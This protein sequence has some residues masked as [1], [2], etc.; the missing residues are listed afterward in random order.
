MDSSKVEPGGPALV[1]GGAM[2]DWLDPRWRLLRMIVVNSLMK[3]MERLRV[4]KRACAL[5]VYLCLII[6][7][8]SFFAPSDARKSSHL[9]RGVRG[10]SRS[11][12]HKTSKKVVKAL[13]RLDI[14][15]D[16]QLLL[17]DDSTNSQPYAVSSPFNLPPFNSLAPISLP[18]SSSTPP[19]C[20]YPPSNPQLPN[21]PS[22]S[23]PSPPIGGG[24]VGG[25]GGGGAGGGDGGYTPSTPPYSYSTPTLPIQ[26]P[27]ASPIG[28]GPTPPFISVPSPSGYIPNPPIY[29]PSPSE[30]NL[31]PPYN[32]EPSP[33]TYTVPNPP[34][35]N[36]P[37][38][39]GLVPTPPVFQ[40]P[41]VYPPPTVP[42]SPN[43]EPTTGLWCVAKPA[44]P[45]PILEEA[46]N[47]ACG[48]GA[49]CNSLQPNQPCFQPNTLIAHA[50]YAF[51][52]YWQR[53]KV[54]GGTCEFG[55][56]AIL[57]TVD[58]TLPQN[59]NV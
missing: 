28:T 18:E 24:G 12:D 31:S 52:S 42:P 1:Q 16:S 41:V 7:A 33:P 21:S 59:D 20:E 29:I 44:V 53:T 30:P 34:S 25:G 40:P 43:T 55:G 48:S 54:A 47:Y 32:Y 27:P 46:M 10:H 2:V 57:V 56:T 26:G 19:F 45:D 58:P 35:V 36:V 3:V 22:I 37:S 50:S 49:D 5:V 39:F 51:N 38:P 8:T 14:T 15:I 23:L 13:K 6:A 9:S 4:N 11:V 17:D